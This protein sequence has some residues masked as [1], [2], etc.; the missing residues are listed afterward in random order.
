VTLDTAWRKTMYDQQLNDQDALKR[1][2]IDA[3]MKQ[4]ATPRWLVSGGPGTLRPK[5][6]CFACSVSA[7]AK[8]VKRIVLAA[9]A[10]TVLASFIVWILG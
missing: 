3:L 1:A 7:T 4:A 5:C 2:G 10:F 9:L 6:A 8:V